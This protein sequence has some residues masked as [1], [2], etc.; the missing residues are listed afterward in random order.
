MMTRE[1]AIDALKEY[2]AERLVTA[3]YEEEAF[4]ARV[5][6]KSD[7]GGKYYAQPILFSGGGT[8]APDFATAQNNIS[9]P[10]IDGWQVTYTQMH[11]PWRV[12]GLAEALSQ[13]DK[14]SFMRLMAVASD[15][16]LNTEKRA[17]CPSLFRDGSGSIG[18]IATTPPAG[19]GVAT[20]VVQLQNIAEIVNFYPRQR[21]VAAA[22]LTGAIRVGGVGTVLVQSV[23]RALGRIT[24]TAATWNAAGGIADVIDG[25]FLFMQDHARN[26]GARRV[27]SGLADWLPF[28]APT[29]G[30][31]FY[32]VDRSVDRVRLAGIYTDQRG[33]PIVQAHQNLL[34]AIAREGMGRPDCFFENHEN[35]RNLLNA[36]GS[37]VQYV[38]DSVAGIGFSGVR[39]TGSRGAATVYADY[40]CQPDRIFCLTLKHW[41]LIS[42]KQVPH[43][44]ILGAQPDGTLRVSNADAIEGRW[45]AYSNLMCMLPGGSGV[46]QTA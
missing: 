44:D 41:K 28:T 23:D 8:P 26:A 7:C 39:V 35:Y 40:N 38:N 20:A 43:L 46:G 17:I 45:K 5:P 29:A 16:A 4:F 10:D 13:N 9:A 37:K 30:E 34:E 31:N 11:A 6:K 12:S 14:Q 3:L 27:S 24:V 1:S 15:S 22:T 2:Y 42:A 32:A 25:D 36:L 19:T 18:Q 33:V 21:L